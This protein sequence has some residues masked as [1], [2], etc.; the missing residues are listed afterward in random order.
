MS[1][2]RA[3]ETTSST[4]APRAE[5]STTRNS[6]SSSERDSRA[7]APPRRARIPTSAATIATMSEKTNVHTSSLLAMRSDR[8]GCVKTKSNVNAATTAVTA[9]AMRPPMIAASSTG[10]TSAS[11]M[12]AFGR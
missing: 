2:A 12:S 10:M 9:P 4:S 6:R 5:S 1:S 8:Y 7:A 3:D 11:A